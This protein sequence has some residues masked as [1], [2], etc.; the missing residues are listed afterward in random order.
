MVEIADAAGRDDRDRHRVGDR[1]GEREVEADLRAVPVHGGEQ[2]LARA[3]LRH[4][5]RVGD[6]VDAGRPPAAV[7]EDLPAQRLA[8]ARDALGVDGDDD[9]LA[10]EFFRG[11]ADELAVGDRRGID[12]GLVGAGEQEVADVVGGAHAA[13]DG[14]RH[15]ADFRGA[16]HDVEQNAAVLVARGDVEEAELVRARPVVGDRALDRIARVA[17]VDEVD[18]L[19]DAAVLDVEAGDDAGLEGHRV[20]P[21]GRAAD[22]PRARNSASARRGSSRPS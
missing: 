6:R 10:A 18:A 19:D 2:D 11:E 14:Q 21:S 22:T 8:L 17:Q 20:L 5:P 12:R 16:A 13:A 15:E 1:A 9:A 4:L 7:G 3:E